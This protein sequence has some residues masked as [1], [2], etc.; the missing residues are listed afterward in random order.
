MSPELYVAPSVQNDQDDDEDFDI[1]RYH[2]EMMK[3]VKRKR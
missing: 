3:P 2:S 1:T